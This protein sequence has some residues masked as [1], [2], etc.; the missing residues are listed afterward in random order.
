[1]KSEIPRTFQSGFAKSLE[2]YAIMG[3]VSVAALIF[4]GFAWEVSTA[5]RLRNTESTWSKTLAS[6][7]ARKATR[8]EIVATVREELHHEMA[9]PPD[10]GFGEAGRY[11]A[12]DPSVDF[13]SLLGMTRIELSIDIRLDSEGRARS[14]DVSEE[15]VAP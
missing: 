12:P 10:E 1:M 4:A 7:V 14:Y 2:R 3:A 13:V 11:L 8:E 5:F 15:L 9:L 6:L